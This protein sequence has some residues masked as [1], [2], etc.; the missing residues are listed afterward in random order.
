MPRERT[1]D[2]LD[3]GDNWYMGHCP[4]PVLWDPN[5]TALLGPAAWTAVPLEEE[6]NWLRQDEPWEGKHGLIRVWFTLQPALQGRATPSGSWANQAADLSLVPL[7]SVK[8]GLDDY[9]H[10]QSLKGSR[11][12]DVWGFHPP[13]HVL[14][15]L[16]HSLFSS[17]V[18]SL[19]YSLIH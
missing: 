18:Y 5:R 3:Q 10:L 2:D 1:C 11:A 6:E 12:R 13:G 17:L 9:R 15:C 7:V 4:L 19:I 16:F 8:I 14:V